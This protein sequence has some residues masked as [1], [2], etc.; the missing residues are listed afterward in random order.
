MLKLVAAESGEVDETTPDE[1]DD[2]END[3]EYVIDTWTTHRL[4]GVYPAAGGY[5][6]Q[7]MSLMRDWRRMT[8][9]HIRV[10][11]GVVSA[12]PEPVNAPDW[13]TI[14]QD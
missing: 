8:L 1:P 11:A 3:V 2:F 4:R 12:L 13:R 7:D 10:K 9:Y 5:D 6:N 14:M